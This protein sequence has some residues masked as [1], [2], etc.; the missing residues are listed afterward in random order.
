MAVILT[1][2]SNPVLILRM[3][4]TLRQQ[5]RSWNTRRGP[6]RL[7]PV[8]RDPIVTPDTRG[9]RGTVNGP[10]RTGLRFRSRVLLSLTTVA[11]LC[12]TA[13]P[14][15]AHVPDSDPWVGLAGGHMGNVQW[16]VK[17]ARPSGSAAAQRPCLQVGTK[18]QRSRFEYERSRYQG[19]VGRSTHLAATQPPLIVAGAQASAD[20]RV[21]LT[22]VG[23]VASPAA[24]R[25][26]VT[27]KDGRQ[28]TIQLQE[29]SPTTE[30]RA[31][32]AHF[33]YAAF[34]ITGT[35]SVE[36][37]VTESASGRT[38]WEEAYG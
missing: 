25:V 37:L 3:Q 10:A 14:A 18:R 23:M 19:C 36:R 11:L 24:R 31:G 9:P 22:A 20:M 8:R 29:P 1:L 26:E 7:F 12:I 28:A 34:A 6:T 15:L 2:R 13:A 21:S 35:W 5:T 4:E 38:L 27:Y 30:Q 32:L 16:S 17:V 33:R